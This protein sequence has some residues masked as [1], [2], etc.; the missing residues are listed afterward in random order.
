MFRPTL[1]ISPSTTPANV[2]GAAGAD[3]SHDAPPAAPTTTTGAVPESRSA[4]HKIRKSVGKF[5]RSNVKEP[6]KKM[7][8][9]I[10][11]RSSQSSRSARISPSAE[12]SL[13]AS[14]LGRDG[15]VV[16]A[17]V[18]PPAREE[19]S[20]SHAQS[21]EEVQT[22]TE[23][24]P[25]EGHD[26][27]PDVAPAKQ[28][29]VVT[30]ADKGKEVDSG[31]HPV[32]DEVV[33]SGEAV[34]T[35]PEA[36]L[37]EGRDTPPDVA[38]AKQRVGVTYADKGKGVDAGL[39]GRRSFSGGEQLLKPGATENRRSS[40]LSVGP[41]DRKKM[42]HLGGVPRPPS[43]TG[44]SRQTSV[45]SMLGRHT[46]YSLTPQQVKWLEAENLPTKL[47]TQMMFLSK[48]VRETLATPQ[49]VEDDLQGGDYLSKYEAGPES[50]SHA[51]TQGYQYHGEILG[52]IPR[53]RNK[54]D[55]RANHGVIVVIDRSL[56][57]QTEPY[58]PGSPFMV[59]SRAGIG[60]DTPL[61]ATVASTLQKGR[62]KVFRPKNRALAAR[63]STIAK[64]WASK[65]YIP[66]DLEDLKLMTKPESAMAWDGEAEKMAIKYGMTADTAYPKWARNDVVKATLKTAIGSMCVTLYVKCLQSADLD[67]AVDKF[68]TD[69]PERDFNQ[70]PLTKDEKKDIMRARVRAWKDGSFIRHKARGMAPMNAEHL[71]YSDKEN[72]KCIG[73]IEVKEEDVAYKEQVP[74]TAPTLAH[75]GLTGSPLDPVVLANALKRNPDLEAYIKDPEQLQARLSLTQEAAQEDMQR[76]LWTTSESEPEGA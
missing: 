10:S 18:N 70:T 20:E 59:H 57:R 4:G 52:G 2:H 12:G 19:P 66:Y 21:G 39:K 40:S 58:G 45:S 14:Q 31:S 51:K 68:K 24:A 72:F 76:E 11:S 16:E 55:Y 3:A 49:L 36:A 37:P 44:V 69:H 23:A 47:D 6:L 25:P 48:E 42:R 46:P 61:F 28:R 29:V 7:A 13:A 5:V 50:A 35:A 41:H 63:V 73:W 8:H 67:G 74:P 15:A 30:Y 9:T 56:P 53:T 75:T 64:K 54:G 71:L 22:Q 1:P 17:P 34:Q 32:S 27:R 62:Y 33:Q 43:F 65:N 38:P 26:T 60:T